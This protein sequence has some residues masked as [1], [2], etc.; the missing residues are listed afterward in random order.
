MVRFRTLRE[1]PISNSSRGDFARETDGFMLQLVRAAPIGEP[2][3]HS[4]PLSL[5]WLTYVM[6]WGALSGAKGKW[7]SGDGQSPINLP[8]PA[9]PRCAWGLSCEICVESCGWKSG[10]WAKWAPHSANP[11]SILVR[12]PALQRPAAGQIA[13]RLDLRGGLSPSASERRESPRF[14]VNNRTSGSPVA[15][16]D[17]IR[18]VVFCPAE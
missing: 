5:F 17:F 2:N 9:E 7:A 10:R 1:G 12:A 13:A 3:V 16:H 15:F 8:S 4:A 6:Y 14:L 18:I 11:S